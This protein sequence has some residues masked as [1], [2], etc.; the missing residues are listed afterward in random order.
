MAK[1]FYDYSPRDG[2]DQINWASAAANVTRVLED[3]KLDREKRKEEIDKSISDFNK[4]AGEP[5]AGQHATM[6]EVGLNY[7]KEATE[8]MRTLERQLKSGEIRESDFAVRRQNLSDGTDSALSSQKAFQE[9][10]A[11]M[12]KDQEEGKSS[13][14]EMELMKHVEGFGN[15]NE[16]KFTIHPESGK[17]M[18][19]KKVKNPSTG[20]MEFSTNPNDLVS[21]DYLKSVIHSKKP[22]YKLEESTKNFTDNL[23]LIESVSRT[24]GDRK[25]AGQILTVVGKIPNQYDSNGNRIMNKISTDL[26]D[27]YGLSEVQVNMLNGYIKSEDKWID[28]QISNPD[29]MMSVLMDYASNIEGGRYSTTFDPEEAA[30]DPMLILLKREGGKVVPEITKEQEA[31]ARDY[32]KYS[33]RSKVDE[34]SSIKTNNDWKRPT[35][36]R[37]TKEVKINPAPAYN[38][39]V[40][41]VTADL[42]DFGNN[43]TKDEIFSVVSKLGGNTENSEYEEEQEGFV[44]II[45]ADGK[46]KTVAIDGGQDSRNAVISHLKNVSSGKMEDVNKRY[47]GK[48]NNDPLD[49]GIE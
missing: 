19:A 22:K 31:E 26:A 37:A 10:F 8:Y 43:T 38:K 44:V 13:L 24:I 17:V 39:N 29:K 42:P 48:V 40:D 33:I 47:E 25:K 16:I 27:Q 11:E 1:T 49:L 18:I 34:T 2:E 12:M 7:A 30:N 21:A 41:N 4:K 45:N 35:A 20:N 23:G 32:M 6:R 5:A 36:P 15:M 28:G 14:Y 3:E 9:R 46:K